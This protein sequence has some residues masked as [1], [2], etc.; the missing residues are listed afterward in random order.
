MTPEGTRPQPAA[1]LRPAVRQCRFSEGVAVTALPSKLRPAA[2]VILAAVG[3]SAGPGSRLTVGD[4]DRYDALREAVRVWRAG[5][6]AGPRPEGGA[7]LEAVDE[8]I[9]SLLYDAGVLAYLR[10]EASRP[11]ARPACG[12][13]PLSRGNRILLICEIAAAVLILILAGLTYFL[14]RGEDPAPSVTEHPTGS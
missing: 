9:A 6:C 13:P 1:V 12:I 7:L 2:E 4:L 14:P 5:G 11:A 8:P 10:T 3:A